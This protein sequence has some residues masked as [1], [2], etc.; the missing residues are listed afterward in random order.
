M[1]DATSTDQRF[2][3]PRPELD[4]PRIFKI[5]GAANKAPNPN[6]QL[7][8]KPVPI[9]GD[10]SHKVFLEIKQQI[11][12]QKFDLGVTFAPPAATDVELLISLAT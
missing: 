12:H 1:E 6:A 7:I 4:L 11:Q 3:R 5:A 9:G 10:I 8:S 2:M